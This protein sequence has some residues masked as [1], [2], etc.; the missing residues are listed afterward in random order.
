[1][2]IADSDLAVAAR[3]N[4]DAEAAATWTGLLRPAV[5]LRALSPGEQVVGYLGGDPL[6]PESLAWPEWEGQGPLAFVGAIDCGSLPAG[7]LDLALPTDGA[8]LFFYFDGQVGDDDATVDY[9]RPE[10][11]RGGSRVIY[12]PAHA[13]MTQRQAPE[14][15]TAY[16]MVPLAAELIATAPDFEH[17][18][19]RA[20]FGDPYDPDASPS[21][22]AMVGSSFSA[23]LDAVR[24]SRAPYHQIG[25]YAQPI[26]GSAETE[27]AYGRFSGNDDEAAKRRGELAGRLVLL[28]Q[29]GSDGS[30]GM[31]WGDTG[32][33]YWLIDPDDLAARRFEAAL[34]TWQSH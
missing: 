5:R 34:F 33:L 15:I 27:A 24:R 19:F 10:S 2:L 20:A 6:L 29:L 22:Q 21:A 18:S 17:P 23:A 13:E 16:P 7:E 8:L 14:G 3:Q 25:G 11:T 1:M 9:W 28:A 31:S 4:L 32:T 26:Q 12:V 30:A